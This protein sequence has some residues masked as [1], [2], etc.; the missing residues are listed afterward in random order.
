MVQLS[1]KND[2]LIITIIFGL[3]IAGFIGG[4]LFA[5]QDSSVIQE[6]V[7]GH[8]TRNYEMCN[9]ELGEKE[10][11]IAGVYEHDKYYCVWTGTEIPII[12]SRSI[13][14]TEQHEIA[15]HYIAQDYYHFCEE[16]YGN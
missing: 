2:I 13:K 6:K 5:V 7:I 1:V 10:F 8:I 11:G 3:I 12:S 9:L 14:D 15:H 4:Y 16:Y